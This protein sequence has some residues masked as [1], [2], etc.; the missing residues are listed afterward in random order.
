MAV[1]PRS[2]ATLAGVVVTAAAGWAAPGDAV[3]A[4]PAVVPVTAV[5]APGADA[6]LLSG[7]DGMSLKLM[8]LMGWSAEEVKTFLVGVK[9]DVKD[10]SLRAYADM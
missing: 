4:V 6:A 2:V 1:A 7:L 8:G 3:P 9:V 10:P 5:A